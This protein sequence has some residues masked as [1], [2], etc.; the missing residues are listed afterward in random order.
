MSSTSRVSRKYLFA[1]CLFTFVLAAAPS[2]YSAEPSAK[3]GDEQM[4]QES[5][6]MYGQAVAHA[7]DALQAARGNDLNKAVKHAEMAIKAARAVQRDFDTMK[8]EQEAQHDFAEGV[9]SLENALTQANKGNSQLAE[10]KFTEALVFWDGFKDPKGCHG[11]GCS[12]NATTGCCAT[13]GMTNCNRYFPTRKCTNVGT[14][15]VCYCM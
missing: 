1:F 13:P 9:K 7:E 12:L 2:S 8:V 14:P 11:G 4:V 15:C 5:S 6:S 10:I 3:Q